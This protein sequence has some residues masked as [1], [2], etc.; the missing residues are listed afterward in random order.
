MRLHDRIH[1]GLLFKVLEMAE[2]W[3]NEGKL[4]LPHAAWLIARTRPPEGKEE[5]WEEFKRWLLDPENARYFRAFATWL[6]LLTR[7]GERE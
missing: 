1:R 3:E 5:A 7:G 4:Y 6:I 2:F